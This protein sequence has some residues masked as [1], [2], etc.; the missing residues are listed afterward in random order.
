M[1]MNDILSINCNR[2]YNIES[3]VIELLSEFDFN[4]MKFFEK[5]QKINHIKIINFVDYYSHNN[6]D[7]YTTCDRV[8]MTEQFYLNIGKVKFTHQEFKDSVKFLEFNCGKLKNF[9][10]HLD[11]IQ[12]VKN[13]FHKTIG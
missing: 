11:S 3:N 12:K 2:N 5:S 10:S 8:T 6:Y 1:N 9:E 4:K 13:I 7:I